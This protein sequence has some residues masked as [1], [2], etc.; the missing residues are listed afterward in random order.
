[1]RPIKLSLITKWPSLV[2]VNAPEF[3]LF[4]NLLPFSVP[5]HRV[6]CCSKHQFHCSEMVAYE[7][8]GDSNIARSWKAVASDGGRLTGS[9]LRQTTTLVSLRDTLKTVGQA[10][11]FI[12]VSAL[13]NPITRLKYECIAQIKSASGDCFDEILDLL[14]QTVNTNPELKVISLRFVPTGI[15]SSLLLLFYLC[16]ICTN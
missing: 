4:L 2:S 7:I 10:T 3:L 13:T 6:C 12:L 9:V 14:T 16:I 8:F 1:M 15:L 5:P 11:R